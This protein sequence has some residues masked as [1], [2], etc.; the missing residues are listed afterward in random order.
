M[1]FD[2]SVLLGARGVQLPD[3]VEN[4]QKMMTLAQ[5]ANASRQQEL[6][7]RQMQ[8]K[9]KQDEAYETELPSLVSSGFSNESVVQA[10]SRNPGAAGAILAESDKRA[11]ARLDAAKTTSEIAKAEAEAMQ[12]R[13]EV[14]GGLA[15]HLSTKQDLS[16]G[17]VEALMA[18]M[19]ALKLDPAQFGNPREFGDARE[20]LKNMA[21]T[22]VSAAK[23]IEQQGLAAQR[24]ETGRHNLATEGH[25]AATLQETGRHNRVREGQLGQANRIAGDAAA[26]AMTGQPQEIMVNG[27]PT[28][29]IYD[30]RSGTFFDAN[31]RQP[32]KEGLG[33]KMEGKPLTEVQGNATAFGI[34]MKDATD[35]IKRL[36]A[37]GAVDPSGLNVAM[38]GGR[39]PLGTP[40]NAAAGLMNPQAQVYKQAQKNWVTA[41]LRKESGAAIPPAEME[42]EIVKWFPVPGDRADVIASK[43]A[44]REVAERAMAVQAGPGGRSIASDPGGNRPAP[45]RKGQVIDGY[46]FNGGDPA[47][48]SNWR[49]VS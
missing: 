20:W 48:K 40:L 35:T 47:A 15:Y 23:Q 1:G 33:P 29:A 31:T 32:I 13:L 41:N 2:T 39:G 44:A 21:M 14:T 16:R 27:V 34:R 3:P 17:D 46:L 49:K 18:N 9:Q 5:V 4:Y 30:R 19:R 6:T 37:S 12:K 10:V 42:A 8:R 26:A 45:P 36:E 11:K 22:T 38:A 7:L 25:Q 28:L 24:A 43:A